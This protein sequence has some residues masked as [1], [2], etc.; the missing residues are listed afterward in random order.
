MAPRCLDHPTR[1]CRGASDRHADCGSDTNQAIDA[2]GR[3]MSRP[4]TRRIDRRTAERL[5]R[6]EPAGP[7]ALADLLAA[8]AVTTCDGD[9]AGEQDAVSAFRAV[10]LGSTPQPRRP[11]VLKALLTKLLTVKI[12]TAALAVATV[13]G[14]AV[15]A[16][17]G[18]LPNVLGGTS[19]AGPTTSHATSTTSEPPGASTEGRD[20]A[21]DGRGGDGRDAEHG[22]AA[23]PSLIGLC[24]AYAGGA[25]SNSGKALDTSAFNAL[26]TAAGG[27][28]KVPAYCGTVLDDATRGGHAGG[29]GSHPAAEPTTKPS[30]EPKPATSGEGAEHAQNR[31]TAHPSPEPVPGSPG[32]GAGHAPVPHPG[33]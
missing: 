12:A 14:V 24:H 17:T 19:T 23:S 2:E 18:V 3:E 8:A 21:G 4:R 22:G 30:P 7:D 1:W 28:E 9:L 20:Y 27:R 15:T 29:A 33:R 32:E 31:P 10:H 11:S 13:G 6:G 25:G 5:L 16:T 26:I